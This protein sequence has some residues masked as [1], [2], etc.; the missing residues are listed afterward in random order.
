MCSFDNPQYRQI[1]YGGGIIFRFINLLVNPFIGMF[2]FA[3]LVNC[4]ERKVF[5]LNFCDVK[6]L[7]SVDFP[8]LGN[9]KISTNAH[10]M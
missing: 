3:Y 6:A 2:T 10:P 4:T 7:N 9:P 5:R 1:P 8:T